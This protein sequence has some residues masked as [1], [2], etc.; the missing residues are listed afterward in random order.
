MKTKNGRQGYKIR[1]CLRFIGKKR[2]KKWEREGIKRGGEAL[3]EEGE[4]KSRPSREERKRGYREKKARILRL[5]R[6][7]HKRKERKRGMRGRRNS[8]GW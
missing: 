2:R 4:K 1:A 3:D 8:V 6:P 5:K 7:R